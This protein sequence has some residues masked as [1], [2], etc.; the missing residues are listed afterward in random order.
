MVC[1]ENCRRSKYRRNRSSAVLRMSSMVSLPY[2]PMVFFD[3]DH[4]LVVLGAFGPVIELG[5]P[6][7]HIEGAMPH[8]LFDH[9]Q[10]RPGI[11]ELGGKGMPK[12]V[13]RICRGD[14]G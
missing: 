10:R 11:E 1:A 8:Q 12:R 6:E 13:R 3:L 9:L 2:T 4:R 5:I 14:A 7:R